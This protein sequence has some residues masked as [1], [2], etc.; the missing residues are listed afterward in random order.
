MGTSRVRCCSLRGA[1]WREPPGCVLPLGDQTPPA[2]GTEP[3]EAASL[4]PIRVQGALRL[5]GCAAQ[6]TDQPRDEGTCP[7]PPGEWTAEPGWAL[8]RPPSARAPTTPHAALSD[9]VPRGDLT[10]AASDHARLGRL[11]RSHWSWGRADPD[12]QGTVTVDAQAA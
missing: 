1:P 8:A 11:T 3:V 7:A 5:T 12:F 10:P 6:G 2:A 4:A 9:P